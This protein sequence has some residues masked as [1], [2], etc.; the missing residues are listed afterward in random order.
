[1]IYVL[2]GI[3]DA[4]RV[5]P[6]SLYLKHVFHSTSWL[7]IMF[8]HATGKRLIYFEMSLKTNASNCKSLHNKA[9]IHKYMYITPIFRNKVGR[10]HENY[11]LSF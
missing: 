1:M 8:N 2:L 4:T 5:G 10:A 11:L 7:T 3:H 9:Y 6:E